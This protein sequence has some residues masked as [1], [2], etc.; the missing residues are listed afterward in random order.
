[1]P[2]E[3]VA[4]VAMPAVPEE[5][6]IAELISTGD[7]S[8]LDPVRRGK[9]LYNL[10]KALGLNPISRPFDFLT[11]KDPSGKP[12]TIL[13]ANRTASDQLRFNHRIVS[14]VVYAGPL[15]IGDL[16]RPDVY[17]VELDM[18]LPL[19]TDNEGHPTYRV[20]RAVGCVA[21]GT[22]QGDKLILL[23]GEALANAI[24]KCYTKA[25]RRGTLSIVGL[26]FPDETE[27][28]DIRSYGGSGVTDAPLAP[29]VLTPTIDLGAAYMEE[30]ANAG[31]DPAPP[32][33]NFPRPLPA[34]KPPVR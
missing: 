9:Y 31:T 16:I 14:D 3:S 10:C 27:V 18:K 4:V 21:T 12:K 23:T 1:V 5:E 7:L 6:S 2:E 26:G 22:Y 20:E 8:S 11:L 17:C 24:M 29:R 34:A 13:Y 33:P 32:R 30:K 28:P 25:L 19:D 15:R